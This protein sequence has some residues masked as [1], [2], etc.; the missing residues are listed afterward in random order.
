M[1][2]TL[3]TKLNFGKFKGYTVEEIIDNGDASYLEWAE[4]TIDWFE[5][6]DDVRRRIDED[7]HSDHTS[8]HDDSWHEAYD[9]LGR[10]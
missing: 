7:L 1:I 6:T 2:C 8:W 4:D 9:L 3:Q 5:L 10:G